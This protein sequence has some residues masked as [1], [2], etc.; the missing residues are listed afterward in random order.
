MNPFRSLRSRSLLQYVRSLRAGGSEVE[1]DDS[2]QR[3]QLLTPLSAWTPPWSYDGQSWSRGAKE[4]TENGHGRPE[5]GLA[6]R[7]LEDGQPHTSAAWSGL[8]GYSRPHEDGGGQPTSANSAPSSVD[9]APLSDSTAGTGEIDAWS[10]QWR[11]A[12]DSAQASDFGTGA[13][14]PEAAAPTG[15]GSL[16][17][18][19]VAP[20]QLLAS[21]TPNRIVIENQMLG[22]PESVWGIDGAGDDNIEGFATDFSVD[23]GTTINFKINTDSTHYRIDVY[24]VGYYQGNGARL[25]DSFEINR[26]SPQIQPVPLFDPELKLVDAGNW[27]I[28]A[29]WDVPSD[30]VSGAY[31]AHMTRL[32]GEAGENHIPFVVRDDENPSDITFQTADTTWQAYNWWGGYNLYFSVEGERASAVSYNRPFVTREPNFASGP[33][34]YIWGVEYPAIRWLE[35]NGYDINYISGI[36]VARD[37][38]QLLNSEIFL[39]VGHDEYWSPEQRANVEAARDAGVNLSFWTGNEVYWKTEWQ[40]S[41]DGSGTPYRTMVLYKEV[42]S[43]ADLDPTNTSSTWRDP[44]YGPGQPENALVGNLFIADSYREDAI[45]VPYELSNFRFWSNTAVADLQPGELYTLPDNILGYEW[46]ADVDN[47]FR[48]AGLI[49]L[50]STTLQID[51]KLLDYGRITG[52]GTATHALTLYRAESGAL[53]FGAGTVY[54]AWGLDD[55][56]DLGF[57]TPT[58]INI[59]QSMVNLFADMGV[60]PETLMA[61][62]VLASQ[63]TDTVAPTSTIL[64][65]ASGSTFP[66]YNEITIAG[67]AVDTGGGLVA[68]VEVSTDGGTRWHRATGFDNWTYNWRPTAGGVYTVLTRAVDDSLNIETVGTGTTVNIDQPFTRSLFSTQ[69]PADPIGHDAAGVNLGVRF[70]STQTGEIA[71]IRYY[72]GL[73]D[74]GE[75]V[76]SLWTAD[77]TLLAQATFTGESITGWQT[78]SFSSPVTIQPGATYVAS[79]HTSGGSYASTNN[80]FGTPYSSGPLS[81]AG[82]SFYAYGS[83]PAFPTLPGNETNYWV[84]VLFVPSGNANNQLPVAV[85]DAVVT[86]QNQVLTIATAALLQNDSDP[87]IEPVWIAGISNIIGGTAVFD[88]QAATILFT[89][90]TD[91]LGSAGF[92]Y[93]ITDGQ[94]IAT[95]SVDISVVP[96]FEAFSLFTSGETPALPSVSDPSPVNLGTRFV[97]SESGSIAGI[98]FY[99]GVGET[100]THSASLWTSSGT[101][102][103]TATFLNETPS[104]W[105]VALFANP[106][107]IAANTSYVASY[108]SNGRYVATTG[109]FGQPFTNGALTGSD[110]VYTYGAGQ[111][112]PA[113]ASGGT[114]Y[115]VDVLFAPTGAPIA[116][117]DG[118]FATDADTPL[119]I[120]TSVLMANDTDPGNDPISFVDVANPIGGTV[121]YDSTSGQVFF[122]PT[123][124]HIGSASFDYSITDGTNPPVSATVSLTVLPPASTASLFSHTTTLATPSNVDPNSVNLGVVF[125]AADS[126]FITGIKYYKSASDVG[127]HT[128]T[129]WSATGAALASGTFVNETQSGWQYVVFDNPVAI[130][131]GTTYVA[132]YLSRG[133]YASTGGFFDV[134]YATTFLST[135]TAAGVYAY[136]SAETF[137]S[138]SYNNTNY[139][140]DV[141]FTPSG[142][143]VAAND[144][145]YTV[146]QDGVL[147]FAPSELVAND[148]D[149]NGDPLS[150]SAVSS[151]VGGT[152]SLVGGDVVFTPTPGHIGAAR[153]SYEV[154]DGNTAPATASVEVIVLPSS[155]TEGLFAYGDA[156]GGPAASDPSSVNLGVQFVAVQSG[157]ISGIKFYK[158]AGDTGAHV[159]S[160]WTSTGTLLASATFTSET[161]SGWQY[162]L[163]QNAVDITAGTTYVAGY[164]SSG[165]YSYSASYYDTPLTSGSLTGIGGAY[166]YDVANAFPAAGSSSNY[167]VDVMFEPFAA[168]PPVAVDDGG[169]TT[170]QNV[171]LSLASGEVTANDTDV[172]GNPLTIVGVTSG[173]GGTAA[174]DSQ[175]GTITFTPDAGFT[176]TAQFGYEVTDGIS[177]SS[178]A[179]VSI[180]VGAPPS[181]EGLFADTATPAIANVNDPEFDRDRRPV[182]GGRGRHHLGHPVL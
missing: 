27:E 4:A 156:P 115:F 60:Q 91:F 134:P 145:G 175:T 165:N 31:F 3:Q 52:D 81:V 50:S 42:K 101:L 37:G 47:G 160:L 148:F 132:S 119:G 18:A 176:G 181:G 169:F 75:H 87:D 6:G 76:G 147:S 166:A 30:A 62:L 33:Q 128:A 73:A 107:S 88:Q 48:P 16:S 143:P 154:T 35:Q 39:S 10:E 173:F 41:I 179:T 58:D 102:L 26:A 130:D 103:G 2:G 65:L 110:G 83:T 159:G 72:R 25:V 1:R 90:D 109:F 111:L 71:G 66:A 43:D 34:D 84:D 163:F 40:T 15:D 56:H 172:N 127:T 57:G 161:S 98:R 78:V 11:A 122:T 79:Y 63:S 54:W 23:N 162:V 117:D 64:N 123:P 85:D 112:F 96:A 139:W 125:T 93:T 29:S 124:G 182:P 38:D 8:F 120:A 14:D 138:S 150:V 32:D 153:F 151:P 86:Q 45:T 95:A 174:F 142:S 5:V 20:P 61:S 105:Q 137:P 17:S 46:N 129:L 167:W 118:G 36:D 131:A 24:R 144:D 113:T 171:P 82:G 21:S 13:A 59:Q 177:G 99:K 94:A 12:V 28:S 146:T 106:I 114:N 121:A 7:A 170:Q 152:V 80:F 149:P 68:A 158:A 133:N 157:T 92:E 89:P 141:L 180:E 49:N 168:A 55:N 104:G 9:I 53:V 19:P 108:L 136:G 140:V 97:A 22:T 126:G 51:T 74:G 135:G 77:G 100:G 69:I 67:A 178:T 164:L 70:T 116:F 44:V 155:T